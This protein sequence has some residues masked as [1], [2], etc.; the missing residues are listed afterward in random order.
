MECNCK[1][2]CR[3]LD[4]GTL[5]MSHCNELE[6]HISVTEDH[7]CFS[8]RSFL[9]IRCH[10]STITKIQFRDDGALVIELSEVS[11][12]RPCAGRDVLRKLGSVPKLEAL[13]TVKT[14]VVR[15][16]ANFVCVSTSVRPLTNTHQ[17]RNILDGMR[18]GNLVDC[19]NTSEN[20]AGRSPRAEQPKCRM[21]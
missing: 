20:I 13:S 17:L 14:F 16:Q 5:A 2:S 19:E 9:Q 10:I 12:V 3:S 18:S 1:D 8:L 21:S 4:F 11:Q 7:L 15:G 6:L